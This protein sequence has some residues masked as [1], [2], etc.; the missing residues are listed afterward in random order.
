[1]VFSKVAKPHQTEWQGLGFVLSDVA[2]L[3]RRSF[4]RRV[5]ELNLTQVQWRAIAQIS[6][7]PGL[8][9]NQLAEILEVQ[10]ISV[11][12]LIDRMEAAGWVKRRADRLDRR[13]INLYLTAKVAPI[14]K[15]MEKHAAALRQEALAGLSEKER[16][17]MLNN[18]LIMRR[19]LAGE[20]R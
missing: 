1:M 17:T 20:D 10:P 16:E 13:A 5:Q 9:Q 19:N 18:L 4:N 15:K 7:N 3:L 12:R 8:R 14:L 11:A 6:R 2:R